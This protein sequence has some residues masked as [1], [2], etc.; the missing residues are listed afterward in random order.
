M[1]ESAGAEAI[2]RLRVIAERVVAS[3]RA[4]HGAHAIAREHHRRRGTR[5]ICRASSAATTPAQR[6][7]PGFDVRAMTRCF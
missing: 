7:C 1:K 2:L 6:R 5:V 3:V 4:A